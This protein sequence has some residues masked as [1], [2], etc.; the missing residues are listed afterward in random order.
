MKFIFLLLSSFCFFSFN[1]LGQTFNCDRIRLDS[2]GFT[3]KAAAASWFRKNVIINADLSQKTASAYGQTTDLWVR[4]DNKRMKT[5][6]IL[7][8]RDGRRLALTFVFLANGEVH[9]DLSAQG[10]Y[11][12][13]GGGVYKCTGWNGSL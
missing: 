2:T 9:S 3:T 11:Q 12:S 13:T 4:E 5:S 1:A 8:T 10:G 6:F 7:K